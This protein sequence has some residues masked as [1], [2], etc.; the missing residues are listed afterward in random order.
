M[1]WSPRSATNAYLDA[2]KL[3]NKCQRECTS[4]D[5]QIPKSN[6][7]ISA[8]AA[9]MSAKLIVEVTSEV[10]PSTVALAVA[11][12]QTGGKLVCI[13]PEPDAPNPSRRA[14]HESGLGDMVEFRASGDPAEALFGYDNI[15]F[16]L[17]DCKSLDRRRLSLG[18]NPRRSV[19]VASNLVEGEKGFG[20]GHLRG[21]EGETRVRNMKHPVG[22]GMEITMIGKGNDFGKRR[23]KSKSGSYCVGRFDRKGPGGGAHVRSTDRS[24]WVFQVDDKSGEEHIFRMPKSR[25]EVFEVQNE[26]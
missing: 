14:I 9:G 23:V 12:R 25:S 7:F 1:D 11:A 21:V 16:S 22:R 2:L 13:L 18:V 17:V 26:V 19:V 3:C 20:P 4:C 6:E 15:D 24:K 5:P 10:S 8:L